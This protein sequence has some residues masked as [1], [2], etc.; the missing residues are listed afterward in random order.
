MQKAIHQNR[1][2]VAFFC[3]GWMKVFNALVLCF[4]FGLMA[5]CSQVSPFVDAR[6]EAGQITPVGSSRPGSPVVCS[7]LWREAGERLALAEA[8]CEKLGKKA[9]SVSVSSFDCKLLT[10]V[11]ETFQC[12]SK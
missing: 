3:G 2:C 1:G 7:G 4:S 5:G 12:V 9:V 11:K 8:E 10:P 6:R